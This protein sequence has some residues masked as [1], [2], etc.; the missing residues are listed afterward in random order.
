MVKKSE[1]TE[2]YMYIKIQ[3]SISIGKKTK[4]TLEK[5]THLCGGKHVNYFNLAFLIQFAAPS[6]SAFTVAK[7]IAYQRKDAWS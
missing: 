3:N 5:L 4:Q 2:R 1:S 7:L 6:E